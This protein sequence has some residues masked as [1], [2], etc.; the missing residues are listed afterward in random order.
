MGDETIYRILHDLK[1]IAAIR[2]NDKLYSESGLLNLD[3]GGYVSSM[4]RWIRGE[5][6]TRGMIAINNVIS[7]SFAIAESCFRKLEQ[8]SKENRE[9]RLQKIKSYYL[10]CKIRIGL[11]DSIIG[12]KN[13]RNTYQQDASILARIDVTRERIK[14]GLKELDAN[15]SLLR[16]EIGETLDIDGEI[17]QDEPDNM[18][19]ICDIDDSLLDNI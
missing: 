4:Q 7:D 15:I 6:R 1:V 16:Q 17:L 8:K 12:L 18:I 14:Q 13:L 11:S 2:D 10:I 3:H 9:F 19:K 5:N